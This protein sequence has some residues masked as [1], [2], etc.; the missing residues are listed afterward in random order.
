MAFAAN[1]SRKRKPV[2]V[3]P[4]MAL[5]AT[6]VGALAACNAP[7]TGSDAGRREGPR[8]TQAQAER[9]ASIFQ[10]HCAGCHDLDA[11]KAR[12]PN[13]LAG[14]AFVRRWNNVGELFDK[15]YLTMP[16]DKLLSLDHEAYLD[17]TA[18][19]A[20][21]NGFAA[22]PTALTDDTAQQRAMLLAPTL[23]AAKPLPGKVSPDGY[24]S[25]AQATRGRAYFEGS[26]TVCHT[27]TPKVVVPGLKLDPIYARATMVETGGM[28]LGTRRM[29]MGLA[30]P[31]QLDSWTSV[32]AYYER[33][34]LSM[35]QHHPQGLA[36]QTYRDIVA[37]L[38]QAN[39]LPAGPHD[40]PADTAKLNALPILPAGFAR[41]ASDRDFDG[42][43]FVIGNGCKPQPEGCGSTRPDPT[44]RI[45]D[46]VI[47]TTGYPYG[48]MYTAK[49]YKDFDLRFEYRLE[50]E[51]TQAPGD[52]Y[53]GNSGYF[54]FMKDPA[55]W[56]RTLEITTL[57]VIQFR[58]IP[59]AGNA[60]YT[61]DQAAA[62]WASK[63]IGSWNDL[64][65]EATG[66]QV[67]TW[68]NDVPVSH[69]TKHDFTEPG[70][71]GFQA[72]GAKISWRNLRIKELP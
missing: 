48:V 1:W 6:T 22:G 35:P 47:S 24:Y 34:R 5:L 46:G 60:T 26:C 42:M 45:Q 69:V 36:P 7:S 68:L 67:Q 28:L 39:G 55:V 9:G 70:H 13:T 59:I 17:V 49:K 14:D 33:I 65:I 50:P 8:F 72:E 31:N 62:Q 37:F 27:V 44:Y 20:R 41:L 43:R 51:K 57:P 18:F 2:L 4:R 30:E 58:P 25:L 40:L 38:L 12:H 11:R 32:G 16:A 64:R 56:P 10:S 21:E 3:I 61:Y 15:I 63:P 19:L 52:T 71:I 53:W 29:I 54:L 66:G 23:P